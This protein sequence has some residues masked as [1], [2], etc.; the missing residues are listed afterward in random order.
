MGRNKKVQAKS[1]CI[2][3]S[4]YIDDGFSGK[5]FNRPAVQRMLTQAKEKQIQCIAVKDLSR[6]GRDYLEV[7][8]YITRIFPFFGIRFLAVNDG[9]DSIRPA[10]ADSLAVSFKTVL[11]DLYSRDLSRKVKSAMRFKAQQGAFVSSFAPYGYRKDPEDKNRIVPDSEAAENVRRIFQM[12]ADGK[13]SVQIARIMNQDQILTP[14]QY[15]CRHGCNRIAWNCIQE[16]NF[17]TQETVTKILRDERYTGRAVYGKKK[18]DEVGGLHQVRVKKE[19]WVTVR[20]AHEG[21][22]SEEDYKRAQENMRIYAQRGSICKSGNPLGKKVRCG[23]CGRA[24]IRCGRK[25]PYFA[26]HTPRVTDAYDCPVEKIPE[27]DLMDVIQ[28][29]MRAQLLYAADIKL[30]LKEMN[31]FKNKRQA[32]AGKQSSMLKMGLGKQEHDLQE[33]YEKYVFDELD[34]DKYMAQKADIL[35]KRA[36]IEAQIKELGEK[37]RDD[38]QEISFVEILEI[39]PDM[40]KE[41]IVHPSMVLELVWNYALI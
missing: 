36:Q 4:V 35:K 24:M 3:K 38:K 18:R 17:W 37:G 30:L 23:V 16:D 8:N 41:V 34:R 21:I 20:H 5:N 33:L 27:N 31:S 9:F 6:F 25:Y 10:E 11:Y 19:D 28:T 26:C 32:E 7:G 12:A 14:M 29:A 22:I 2:K 39:M 13:S 40:L 15:K 1:D